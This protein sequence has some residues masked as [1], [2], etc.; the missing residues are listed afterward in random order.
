MLES[1]EASSIAFMKTFIEPHKMW[2]M[3]RLTER[4]VPTIRGQN[5]SLHRSG[6]WDISKKLQFKLNEAIL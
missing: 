4:E 3:S 2:S 1:M 6:G 5:A